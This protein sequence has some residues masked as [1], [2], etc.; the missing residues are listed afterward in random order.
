MVL[1]AICFTNNTLIIAATCMIVGIIVLEQY[2]NWQL[3]IVAMNVVI[4]TFWAGSQPQVANGLSVVLCRCP[5]EDT[6]KNQYIFVWF[7]NT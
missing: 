2:L 1:A 3:M 7:Q 4:M 6:D 5:R